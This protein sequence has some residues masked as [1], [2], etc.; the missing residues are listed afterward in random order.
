MFHP[1][2]E[3]N[4]KKTVVPAFAAVVDGTLYMVTVHPVD[5]GAF[6]IWEQGVTEPKYINVEGHDRA[7]ILGEFEGK[8]NGR[9]KAK[10]T[11]F[12][13]HIRDVMRKFL[14]VAREVAKQSAEMN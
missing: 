13:V 12:L 10:F 2:L 9:Q 6:C 11:E 4:A 1:G 7:A 5:P 8:L 14:D 3:G